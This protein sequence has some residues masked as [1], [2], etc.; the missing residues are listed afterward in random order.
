MGAG[1]KRG[2]VWSPPA[3]CPLGQGPSAACTEGRATV[4]TWRGAERNLRDGSF[5]RAEKAGPDPGSA[6]V[7]R[8]PWPC[9]PHASSFVYCVDVTIQGSPGLLFVFRWA[10]VATRTSLQP[11]SEV[12]RGPLRLD[13]AA[14]L[15][16]SLSLKRNRLRGPSK[17]RVSLLECVIHVFVH[18]FGVYLSSAVH[19]PGIGSTA[20][21][22]VDSSPSWS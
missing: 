8:S 17:P 3:L 19:V 1:H 11:G 7:R 20:M 5:C 14:T 22:K 15:R 4:T 6:G 16:C 10:R 13:S 9:I 21:N 12:K 2:A 18:S